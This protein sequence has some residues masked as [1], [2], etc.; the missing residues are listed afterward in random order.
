MIDA[1][2]RQ[3]HVNTSPIITCFILKVWLVVTQIA[4][5]TKSNT[6]QTSECRITIQQANHFKNSMEIDDIPYT[7]RPS[8]GV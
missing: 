3:L 8:P 5:K 7:E 2:V 6:Q 4:H 1:H